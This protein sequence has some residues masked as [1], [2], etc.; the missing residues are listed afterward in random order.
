MPFLH[1]GGAGGVLLVGAN[2]KVGGQKP[3]MGSMVL[4]SPL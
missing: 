2:W 3:D 1:A 4:E